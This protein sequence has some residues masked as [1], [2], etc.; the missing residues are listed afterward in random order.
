MPSLDSQA[1]SEDKNS[2]GNST[3]TAKS[4]K[5]KILQRKKKRSSPQ[6]LPPATRYTWILCNAALNAFVC[7]NNTHIY[8]RLESQ[9]TLIINAN[10]EIYSMKFAM[11]LFFFSL[12]ANCNVIFWW[13]FFIFFQNLIWNLNTIW[14]QFIVVEFRWNDLQMCN[15]CADYIQGKWSSS[16]VL[17]LFADSYQ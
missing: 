10:T 1:A 9:F 6:P 7:I 15:L 16:R 17:L 8:A 2:Y 5:Q 4:N 14:F 3:T 12:S 13:I 11:E